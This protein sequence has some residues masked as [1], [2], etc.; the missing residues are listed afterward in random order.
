MDPHGG[1]QEDQHLV[2]HVFLVDAS[3]AT[4]TQICEG[5]L[6]DHI[7]QHFYTSMDQLLEI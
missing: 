1:I 2:L 5:E 4:E 3:F 7:G 6:V